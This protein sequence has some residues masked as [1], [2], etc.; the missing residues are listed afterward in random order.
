MGIFKKQN[1]VLDMQPSWTP[2]CQ[3]I[4]QQVSLQRNSWRLIL[5]GGVYE[6]VFYNIIKFYIFYKK[7][8]N[9]RRAIFSRS[10][11]IPL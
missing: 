5:Q 10:T 4:L 11:Y 2:G 1:I 3:N 9:T 8:K 7:I 6:I